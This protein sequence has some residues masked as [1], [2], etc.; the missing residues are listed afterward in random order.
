MPDGS[1]VCQFFELGIREAGI[2]PSTTRK[3][4]VTGAAKQ[5]CSQEI[6]EPSWCKAAA[7]VNNFTLDATQKYF[8]DRGYKSLGRNRFECP[9][10]PVEL[11]TIYLSIAA[12]QLGWAK[13]IS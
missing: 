13:R 10:V 11:G 3:R 8:L 6:Y 12:P 1:P 7:V 9:S 2:A 4:T 5:T